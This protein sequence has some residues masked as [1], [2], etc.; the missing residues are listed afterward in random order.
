MNI[1]S[2]HQIAWDHSR[3]APSWWFYL[4]CG[5]EDTGSPGI[6]WII[7][8]Q[9]L[10]HPSE[11]PTGSMGKHLLAKTHITKLDKLAQS[12]VTN[13]TCSTVN[14]TDL[15][16]LKRQGSRGIT[17][18]SLQKKIIFDIQ[19][20]PYW[21]K[22]QTKCSK[23][24]TKDFETSKFH[25]HMWNHYHMLWFVSAHTPWNTICKWELWWLY[26][27]L[28]NYLVLL[29]TTTLTNRCQREYALTVH[30]IKKQ[31]PSRNN[32]SL[33]LD[34]W[35]SRNTLVIVSVIIEYM[36]QNWP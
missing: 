31:L 25:Q 26:T 8:H 27:A 12:V 16:I 23:I 5:L 21:L 28:G 32:L 33:A 1:P 11:H 36:D 35:T 19:V 24:T 15:A 6:I 34:G 3:H 14:K 30:A 18:V 29:S 9:V 7:C 22:R 10:C 4:H 17:I 20:N 2:N 13:M